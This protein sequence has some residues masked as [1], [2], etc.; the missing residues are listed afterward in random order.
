MTDCTIDSGTCS[1]CR[2]ACTHKPGWFNPGEVEKVAEYLGISVQELFDTKLQVDWWEEDG[3]HPNDVF[4]LSPAVVG[5]TPGDMFSEDPKGTC[6]FYKN[7]LCEIHE[8]KPHECR[9]TLGCQE[10]DP[11]LHPS[12]A[13]AWNDHQ[14]QIRELLG[15]EPYAAEYWS[16]NIFGGMF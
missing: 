7:G 9:Q 3:N 2:S 6:V 13:Y 12:F 5:G 16:S 11:E 8:V 14:D 15:R 1:E 10:L 4:V